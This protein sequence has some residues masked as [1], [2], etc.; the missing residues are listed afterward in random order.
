MLSSDGRYIHDRN[1]TVYCGPRPPNAEDF[2]SPCYIDDAL[3]RHE[4]ELKITASTARICAS[5]LIVPLSD[6]ALATASYCTEPS[7]EILHQQMG[8]KRMPDDK[9]MP[10]ISGLPMA[11]LQSF[12][13]S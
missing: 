2:P 4:H 5:F 6:S 9:Y 3:H 8:F 11:A 13:F 12:L 10:K 1:D 7:Q